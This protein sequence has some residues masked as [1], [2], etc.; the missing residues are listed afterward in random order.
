M[1]LTK[2]LFILIAVFSILYNDLFAQTLEYTDHKP[3]YRQWKESYILDKIEYTKNSTIFYFRF[4]CRSGQG[5]SAIFY[6]PRHPE[7]WYLKGSNGKNYQ[8]KAVKNIRRNSELLTSNLY[9]RQEY[10]SMN[11]FGYTV[12]SCEVHFDRLP[13]SE[14]SA[15]L[16]EGFGFDNDENRFNC[17]NVKLK[18]SDDKELGQIK[19]SEEN[20]KKFEKKFGVTNT[21]VKPEVKVEPKKDPIVKVEPK[22]DDSKKEPVV[23]VV[24]KKDPVK[25]PDPDNPYPISRL[26]YKSDIRCNDKL[27]LDKIKFQDNSTDFIGMVQCQQTLDIVYEFLK[28]NPNATVTIIGHSDIFGNKDKNIEL[29]KQRATK[30]QRMLSIRG[31][32][33][34]RIDIQYH[35][36]NQP[37]FKEGS[38]LNRRVEMS[39]KCN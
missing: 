38:P 18:T 34:F 10:P 20:V 36:P 6:P 19:D 15:S 16:I 13:N 21:K 5:I 12:F 7:A 9:S 14:K 31:I 8:M 27:V 11:G 3:M 35:G 22:K 4:V 29:S 39:V 23:K 32:S 33:P 2:S 17:F 1:N 30:V 25:K 37:L 24:Q 26:R 28:E